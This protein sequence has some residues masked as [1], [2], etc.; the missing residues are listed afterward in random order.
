MRS[1]KLPSC[2]SFLALSIF[3][4]IILPY[5]FSLF[6]PQIYEKGVYSISLNDSKPIIFILFLFI[7]SICLMLKSTFQIIPNIIK[8]NVNKF[9]ILVMF[10]F[11]L[12]LWFCRILYFIFV[13]TSPYVSY[14]DREIFFFEGNS[15]YVLIFFY[16]YLNFNFYP[17]LITLTVIILGQ[18]NRKYLYF[19]L[20]IEF[21][22]SVFIGSKAIILYCL[23]ALFVYFHKEI[24]KILLIFFMGLMVVLLKPFFTVIRFWHLGENSGF[25]NTS[26]EYFISIIQRIQTYIPIFYYNQRVEQSLDGISLFRV[27]GY[28]V[29]DRFVKL[30]Y[31]ARNE[32]EGI[33]LT[34]LLENTYYGYNL[35]DDL[36]NF[37]SEPFAN[38]GYAGV[39]LIL[40]YVFLWKNI[41]QYTANFPLIFYSLYS[42]F[43]CNILLRPHL[44]Y[45]SI[46]ALSIVM[47][48]LS[49]VLIRLNVFFRNKNY[50]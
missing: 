7:T 14:I 24:K 8:P 13:G 39:A 17:Y 23:I 10:S 42:F 29:P 31:Y 45:S 44:S 26:L 19:L 18:I 49:W 48:I 35:D 41:L 28:L 33:T 20:F 6:I 11:L 27:F 3:L 40:L 15:F 22:F 37:F 38:F 12:T 32:D 46:L 36:F 50:L 9:W 5:L 47:I 1:F 34:N 4:T 2:Y 30:P 25:V 16:N 43:I 21:T